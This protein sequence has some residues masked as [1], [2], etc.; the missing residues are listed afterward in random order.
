MRK[1]LVVLAVGCAALFLSPFAWGDD[2][3]SETVLVG[4]TGDGGAGITIKGPYGGQQVMARTEDYSVRYKSCRT[5]YSQ[6]SDAGVTAGVLVCAAGGNDSWLE[7]QRATDIC[8]PGASTASSL[9]FAVTDGGSAT[10]KIF[11]VNPKTVCPP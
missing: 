8:V 6:N 1:L 7:A 11:R 5:S 2:T 10:V 4:G 9:S 3:F